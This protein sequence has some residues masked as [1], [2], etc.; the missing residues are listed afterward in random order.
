[1]KLLTGIAILAA[2]FYAVANQAGQVLHLIFAP[3]LAALH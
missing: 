1:M 2:A 3:V